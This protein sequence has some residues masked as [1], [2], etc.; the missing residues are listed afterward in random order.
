MSPDNDDDSDSSSEIPSFE[1]LVARVE[2]PDEGAAE[3]SQ[4]D[5]EPEADSEMAVGVEAGEETESVGAP[6]ETTPDL[7]DVEL[8]V[9]GG[10]EE[11][12]TEPKAG[13]SVT[14]I[15]DSK[16]DALLELIDDASNVLVV[17]PADTPV[18]YDL[19]AKLCT[20][21]PIAS[22][23]LL[24]TTD[25]SPDERLNALRGYGAGS[26][27]ESVVIAI[28]DQ[29][30]SSNGDGSSTRENR[31]ETVTVET[32]NNPRDLTRLGLLIN[33]HLAGP[34]EGPPAVV[35]FHT[36]ST[37]LQFVEI[38][39]A[40]RFLHV[41]QGRARTANARAHYHLDP[42]NHDEQVLH[43]LRPIFDFTVRFDA[44]GDVAVDS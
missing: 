27:D 16:A 18:E 15:A 41:L 30:R 19:C 4:P 3:S 14:G 40:F 8:Q 25:Q 43:T 31:G 33:K 42:S 32:I 12:M 17:G 23:R 20:T 11:P 1:D 9:G 35:C 28:G 24:V 39:K 37:L 26:F 7:D 29:M 38:E 5:Q 2:G 34:I 6:T 10:S 21:E 36:L 13:E 44:A 22:R